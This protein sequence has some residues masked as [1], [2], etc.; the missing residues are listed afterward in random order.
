[1]Q[2]KTNKASKKTNKPNNPLTCQAKNPQPPSNQPNKS[3]I[4]NQVCWHALVIPIPKRQRPEDFW[5]WLRSQTI[6]FVSSRSVINPISK[7]GRYHPRK[8]TG[9]K[10]SFLCACKAPLAF[11]CFL[12]VFVVC[13]I[14]LTVSCTCLTVPDPFKA[15]QAR[16]SSTRKTSPSKGCVKRWDHKWSLMYNNLLWCWVPL[17]QKPIQIVN[18]F[19]DEYCGELVP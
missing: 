12:F 19:K 2:N 16:T 5:G 15:R 11:V 6:K 10:S 8:D 1:M 17:D 14:S 18:K 4:T 13:A 3:P 9:S 7:K